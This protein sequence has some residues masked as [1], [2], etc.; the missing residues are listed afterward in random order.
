MTE[1]SA[2]PPKSKPGEPVWALARL[3]PAQGFWTERDYLALTA[4]NVL[5][6]Y[7]GLQ[8]CSR[9][10]DVTVRIRPRR[11]TGIE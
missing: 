7:A 6:E 11:R 1:L 5:V 9:L 8:A 3:Y 4:Q 2:R 10:Q